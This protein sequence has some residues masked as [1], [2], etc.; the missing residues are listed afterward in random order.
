MAYNKPVLCFESFST[1]D[2][3]MR[4]LGYEEVSEPAHFL[5]EGD[6]RIKVQKWVSSASNTFLYAIMIR[7]ATIE[8]W[9]DYLQFIRNLFPAIF[10]FKNDLIPANI[11]PLGPKFKLNACI[12]DLQ[13]VCGIILSDEQRANH[14][15]IISSHEEIR[16]FGQQMITNAI[17]QAL[18][19]RQEENHDELEFIFMREDPEEEEDD[20]F[21]RMAIRQSEEEESRR[22]KALENAKQKLQTG[23]ENVL[24]KSEP[25]KRGR[26]GCVVCLES[27]ATICLVE[28]G[29]QVMCDG[30]VRE[31]W[32]R[33]SLAK[34][35]PV[36]KAACTMIT[37]PIWSAIIEEEEPPKKKMKTKKK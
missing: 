32:T 11:A 35:C 9:V 16:P 25:T 33:S 12:T 34:A 18:Q 28:C 5:D 20:R 37:R 31:I 2:A 8:D 36:C 13:R 15:R 4:N 23:W 19:I 21:L 29:H 10:V 17:R 14:Q 6:R 3:A 1:R 26:P 27:E 24:K 22:L 30:C 7:V